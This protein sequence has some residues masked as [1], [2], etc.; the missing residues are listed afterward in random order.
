MSSLKNALKSQKTHRER[1][2]P[3]QRASLG[4]LEKRKDY[5][6]RANDHNQK[7]K[8]LEHL[9]KKALN[10]NPDE[11][12]FHMINSK[13]EEGV[14]KERNKD[15]EYTEEQIKL[16]QTQD[17]K[18]IVNKRTSEKNKIERIKATLHLINTSDKPKN[19][20]TFFV[21]SE[22]EKKKFNVAKRLQTDPSLLNRTHNRPKLEDLKSGKLK[23]ADMDTETME[24]VEKKSSKAYKELHQRL[25][26]EKQLGVVQNKMEIKAALR[27]KVKPVKQV[28]KED[29]NIAPVYLWPQ[30]R[31][32]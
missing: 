5:K 26:R 7:K 11:F 16:M 6:L 23:V 8:A 9:R 15:K 4:L 12:Y 25:E 24:E 14:H 1:H 29:K 21:D 22:K 32:R 18:Y 3:E 17:K 30:E 2:Q 28:V 10:K 27:E 20:H 19:S 13:Q 31:K